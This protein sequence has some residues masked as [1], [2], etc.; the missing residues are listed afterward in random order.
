MYDLI[1]KCQSKLLE[2]NPIIY[3]FIIDEGFPNFTDAQFKS[4]AKDFMKY[5]GIDDG[6]YRFISNYDCDGVAPGFYS[7]IQRKVPA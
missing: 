2:E 3:L 6:E 5:E 4:Y 1:K 7:I